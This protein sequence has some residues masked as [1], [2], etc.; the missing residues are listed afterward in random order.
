MSCNSNTG[1]HN[2]EDY[3]CIQCGNRKV[4]LTSWTNKNPSRRFLSCTD[5]DEFGGWV[6]PPMCRRAVQIIPELLRR[7]KTLELE[8][9]KS[10][11]R[12]RRMKFYIAAT[13]VVV[14]VLVMWKKT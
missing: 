9:A 3:L 5:C 11:A 14:A 13:W 7:V 8:L 2:E 6:D 12:E 1:K 10:K 4:T